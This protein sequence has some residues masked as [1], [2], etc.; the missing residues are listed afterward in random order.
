MTREQE[1]QVAP[2][3]GRNLQLSENRD[4]TFS[5][6]DATDDATA[7][8]KALANRYLERKK[9]NPPCNP[10]ATEGPQPM[11]LSGGN[12]AGK[13]ASDDAPE[14]YS[15]EVPDWL[16]WIAD[17]CPLLPED[18]THIVRGLY[19][20]HPKRQAKL[21]QWYVSAW[22]MAAESE[23]RPVKKENAGRRAANLI[24]TRLMKGGGQ[25]DP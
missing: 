19:R 7:D 11:Q 24:V 15:E 18:K 4:A 17:R 5:A 22:R 10:D 2:P 6:S 8:L 25:I 12:E 23:P 21:A 9:C 1:L 16:S 3:R 13:V 20:L 14:A